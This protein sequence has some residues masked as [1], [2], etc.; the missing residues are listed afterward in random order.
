MSDVSTLHFKSGRSNNCLY[1]NKLLH[2]KGEDSYNFAMTRDVETYNN[3][4][5]HYKKCEVT[6]KTDETTSYPF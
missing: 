2:T 1:C 4:P 5:K 3:P 6:A